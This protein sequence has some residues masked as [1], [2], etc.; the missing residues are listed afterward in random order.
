MIADSFCIFCRQYFLL[1]M[2]YLFYH[3]CLRLNKEKIAI[4]N[5]CWP[6]LFSFWSVFCGLL[7]NFILFSLKYYTVVTYYNI[8]HITMQYCKLLHYYYYYFFFT[9]NIFVYCY[10]LISGISTEIFN[11]NIFPRFKFVIK[12]FFII[13]FGLF[14]LFWNGITTIFFFII[15]I[16]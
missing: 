4:K 14:Y 7:Y 16:I 8:T 5:Y 9:E 6:Q 15:I 12:H 13:V 2:F 11:T 10:L 3:R 1:L